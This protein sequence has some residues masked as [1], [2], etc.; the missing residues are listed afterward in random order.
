MNTMICKTIQIPGLNGKVI[1]IDY[2]YVDVES[3][4]QPIIYIHGYKG[5]KDWGLSN[6]IADTF[7]NNNFCYIKFN[8]SHNGVSHDQPMD[9]VDLEAFGS[10]NY[11]MELQELGL[12]IDWLEHSDLPVNFYKLALIGHSRGGGI[13]LLRTAQ[14]S[15]IH[16]TITWASV[17]DF[18]S[19]FP[20]DVSEWRKTG[21]AH[22]L[23]ARTNQL[24]PHYFQFF[25][26]YFQ[27]EASLNLLEQCKKIKSELMIIHGANDIGV[28]FE[29]AETIHRLVKHSQLLKI[30]DA[31]HTFEVTHPPQNSDFPKP[32]VQVLNASISF[33]K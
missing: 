23:N 27:H 24:M 20:D 33:L 7:A 8:F 30:P 4:L 29:E 9:F 25:E 19:R 2:R 15:R 3:L 21:V 18:K 12:V 13:S 16:K 22:I 11:W 17:C 5:F 6:E 10:N 32:L 28:P 26:S 1:S 31:G 14:D